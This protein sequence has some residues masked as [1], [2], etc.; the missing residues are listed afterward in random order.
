[1][2]TDQTTQF[3][4]PDS[5][6]NLTNTAANYAQGFQDWGNDVYQ[7][8]YNQPLTTGVTNNMGQAVGALMNPEQQ[9]IGGVQGA[10]GVA[11]NAS[12][13][14]GQAANMYQQ[15]AQYDP[16]QLQQY[17]NP[18][19][20]NAAQAT[21]DQL[22]RNLM[23]NILPGV[24]SSFAGAGQFG[25]TRNAD[26]TN[27]AIQ[28]TQTAAAEEIAKANY[29]AFNQANQHYLDW[30]GMG[31]QAASG[32]A[33]IGDSMLQ[34]AGTLGDLAATGSTLSQ[35]NLTN[36]LTGAQ[37]E[38]KALQDQLTANYNDW[39]QQ[40]K[41]PLENLGGLSQA[42][43]AMEGGVKPNIYTP[44]Q[45][46]DDVSKVL[47]IINAMSSGLNDQTI[48]SMVDYLFG[49]GSSFLGGGSNVGV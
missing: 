43:G 2:T 4:Y 28:N 42:I 37:A 24:N 26:F 41:F 6:N 5:W 17:L 12:P 27:R 29:N 20:Q 36:M 14:Y 21:T 25:S 39:M 40:Q 45:Q 3:L 1:M 10:Q 19:T 34:Q 13:L 48:Q 18:Y 8:W 33:G 46:P 23:E 32:L 9:W 49:E 31:Q 11:G 7:N 22:T 44:Q 35:Q 47:A 16:A 15:G 30:A 38:Q